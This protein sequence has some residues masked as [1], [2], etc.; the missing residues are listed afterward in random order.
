MSKNFT[1]SEEMRNFLLSKTWH[2]N[3]RE[4][5]NLIYRVAVLSHD[6]ILRPPQEGEVYESKKELK[7]G[8]I[9]EAEK[10]LIIEALNKTLGN[11]TKAAELLGIS[12]RTLRNKIK[13]FGL[14]DI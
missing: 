10:E 1:L 7:V 14:K 11:R 6:G 5:E 3:V 9:K 8:K 12:V 13:E 2:G 4:L